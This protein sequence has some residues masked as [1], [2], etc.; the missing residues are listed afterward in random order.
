MK[1][2][3]TFLGKYLTFVIVAAVVVVVAL[4][5]L[6]ARPNEDGSR[7][8]TGNG[9]TYSEAQ[10]QAFCEVKKSND[11]ALAGL[12]GIDVP[13]DA[14]S[15]CDPTDLP[16]MGA[17][18][19]Y[20][21]GM[22][23]PAEFV[24]SVNGR[25][26]NEGYGLQCVAGFKQFMFSLSNRYVAAAGGGAKGYATQQAQIEPLGFKWYAGAGGLQDGD[27][28]IWTNGQYGHVAMYYQGK[29]FGQ[30]QYAA[31]PNAGNA[32]SLQSISTNGLAGYYRPNI[33]VKSNPAPN[34]NP[35]PGTGGNQGSTGNT[36]GSTGVAVSNTYTVRRGDT[37]GN[38]ILKAGWYSGTNG[39]YGDNGYAQKVADFNGISPRGLIYPNTVIR[40]P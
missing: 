19:Y 27:W 40:R 29:W 30:N 14:T 39:L 36:G 35:T 25:G 16:Q 18:T 34:P 28:G 37:L 22:A 13:Q 10:E 7:T 11:Q 17:L 5:A 6:F 23:T 12:T 3:L 38:I 15:G 20:K 9:P 1:S 33:Y 26:F 31:D 21:V 8:Y 2:V 4:L 24:N 32:F